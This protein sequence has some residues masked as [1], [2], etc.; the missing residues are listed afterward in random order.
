MTLPFQRTK[1]PIGEMVIPEPTST[2]ETG[3]SNS[4]F[5]NLLR[6]ASEGAQNVIDR[7]ESELEKLEMKKQELTIER[8]GHM[9]MQ[10]IGQKY[11]GMLDELRQRK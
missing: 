3:E 9:E 8:D 11:M 4:G 2:R 1:S 7:I 5:L 10:A 6:A